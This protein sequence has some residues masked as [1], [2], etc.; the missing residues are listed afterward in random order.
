VPWITLSGSGTGP[1]TVNFT[2]ATS[3]ES[4]RTGSL[5]VTGSDTTTIEIS[6]AEAV[7]TVRPPTMDFSA[8]SG[9][10]SLAV[11][12]VDNCAWTAQSTEPWISFSVQ[13]G[14]QL[15]SGTGDAQVTY[16]VAGQCNGA[17]RTGRIDVTSGGRARTLTISQ[18]NVD[19][20]PK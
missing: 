17:P 1:G 4:A 7:F 10:G 18:Q 16:F 6:Q 5:T 19:C 14:M 8:S 12:V 13:G 20:G 9:Q 2:V 15:T 11:D 3:C